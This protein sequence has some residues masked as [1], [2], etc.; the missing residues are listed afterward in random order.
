MT[1]TAATSASQ[2]FIVTKE[3]LRFAEFCDACRDRRY[4][5][6]CY[7]VPGVG[8]TVSARHYSHWDELERLLGP[9]PYRASGILRRESGPWRTV[10][11]T[12]DVVNTPR[13]LQRDH[14]T[15]WAAVY[16]LADRLH[17]P[18]PQHPRPPMPELVIV[19]EADRLRTA[20]L[21]QLRD[22][23][24]RR[25]IGLVLIGMPGLQKRLGRYAQLYSRVG[26]VHQFLPLGGA[27]L[28]GLIRQHSLQLGLGLELHDD[29]Q[30]NVLNSVVRITGGN[31][32]LIERLFAQI[33]RVAQI[34]AMTTLTPELVTAA[35]E[36]LVIGAL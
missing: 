31:F 35:Q 5:G 18:S 32:R 17:E 8:K 4:I 9:P 16:G 12:P 33:E 21:E 7:G 13:M 20:G 28:Q 24:D 23:Y 25:H 34:N 19:D 15:V 36:S 22:M 1:D 2:E 30:A 26:F 10:L 3:Y 29:T 14:D 11:Y 6:L 27:E